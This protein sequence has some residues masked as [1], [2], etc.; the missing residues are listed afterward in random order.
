M[1]NMALA[2]TAVALGIARRALESFTELA[3][4]KVAT[5]QTNLL[6]E[7]AVVQRDLARAEASVRSAR[8][9]ME[10]VIDEVWKVVAAGREVAV[11]QRA[12]LRLAAV[13]G[14]Q[15]AVEAGDLLFHAA[16]AT[17]IHTSTP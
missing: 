13:D 10:A 1:G 16:G 8:C 11:E 6:R 3:R 12:T 5:H 17:S 9:F 7:R 15:R 14:V 4:T 2:K